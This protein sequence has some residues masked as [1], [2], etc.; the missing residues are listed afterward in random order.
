[1]A[2]LYIIKA[3]FKLILGDNPIIECLKSA[4][5]YGGIDKM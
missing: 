2:F 5:I 4:L 1:M 3:V